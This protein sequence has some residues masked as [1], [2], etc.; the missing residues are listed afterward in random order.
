MMKVSSLLV[1]EIE[2]DSA[3]GGSHVSF[4][5]ASECDSSFGVSE[6]ESISLG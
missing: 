2:V 6:D 5:S 1:E 4:P 3:I